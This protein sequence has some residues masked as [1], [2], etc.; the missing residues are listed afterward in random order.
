MYDVHVR[1]TLDLDDDLIQ[2]ARNLAQQRGASMGQVVS[3]LL[4]KALEPKEAPV[5]RNGVPL[6][7]P[8]KNA[9]KPSL[10]LVNEL[11]DQG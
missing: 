11:R 1:T 7:V 2:V 8:K 4:R 3:D 10:D 5:M 9:K 6:F